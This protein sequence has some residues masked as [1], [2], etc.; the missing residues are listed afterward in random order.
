MIAAVVRVMTLR[1]L[2]DRA[3]LVM[4]FVLPPLVF[5]IFSAVFAGTAGDA[6]RLSVAVADLARSEDSRRL[7]AALLADPSL[8]AETVAPASLAV[9][10]KRVK[11]G[12]D[13]AGVVI[14]ADPGAAGAPILVLADP[15][16][17]VAAPL[18]EARVRQAMMRAL[19]D[20]MVDRAAR[21]L[22]PAIGPLT[23][24]QGL[25]LEG[26]EDDLKADAM[27]GKPERLSDHL[28][29]REAVGAVRGG[30]ANIVY[31]AGAVTILFALFSAMHGALS[32]IDERA[33]GIADRILAGPAGMAPVVSGKFLFLAGQAVAQA[34]AIFV[35]AAV[36]Y[37]IPLTAHLASWT[38][39]TIA[40]AAA[41]AGLALGLVA[42]CRTRE[43]GQMFATFVILILAAVG[44]SMAPRFLMPPWLQAIG[45]ATPHAWVIDAYQGAL[46]RDEGPGVLY[47]P[48]LVL[49]L[50]GAA[51]LLIA[52]LAARRIRR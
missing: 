23:S 24:D 2:R 1:L 45:W 22:T 33:S 52:Q 46:A 25:S 9:A 32:L 39:T 13:D 10:R 6:V 3:A 44:G 16:R 20:V 8:R 29:A 4:A 31:Y 38:A 40:A 14:R 50:I 27:A 48:W 42:V 11:S 7:A 34:T 12:A 30:G 49:A 17:A 37:G 18:V 19:P 41:S 51:G 43:Q 26:A 15:G 5:L 36:V 35:T 47:K 21:E 28:V